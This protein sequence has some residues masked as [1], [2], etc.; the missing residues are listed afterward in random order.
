MIS[1]GGE[2]MTVQSDLKKS[3]CFSEKCFR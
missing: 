3:T 1:Q 2:I